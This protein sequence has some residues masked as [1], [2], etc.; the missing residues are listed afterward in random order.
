V[1]VANPYADLRALLDTTR[2][3]D[4]EEEAELHLEQGFVDRALHIYEWLTEREPNNAVYA[5]RREWLAR[6]VRSRPIRAVGTV[7]TCEPEEASV[8]TTLRGV[9]AVPRIPEPSSTEPSSPAPSSPSE[10]SNEPEVSVVRPLPIVRV[11]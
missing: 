5:M 3:L 11:R 1:R 7:Q 4:P 9:P 8:D 6:M 10:A 2:K